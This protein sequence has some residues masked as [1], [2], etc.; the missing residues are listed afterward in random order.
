MN[1]TFRLKDESIL[2][3]PHNDIASIVQ[4]SYGVELYMKSGDIFELDHTLE[5]AEEIWSKGDATNTTRNR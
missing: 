4:L 1:L 2:Q 5:Q 3:V